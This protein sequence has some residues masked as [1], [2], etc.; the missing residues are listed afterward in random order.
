MSVSYEEAKRGHYDLWNY[1][2]ESGGKRKPFLHSA[3]GN[4]V[5]NSCWCCQLTYDIG[6]QPKY[7][8]R[9]VSVCKLCP[10]DWNGDGTY[11]D[12]ACELEP[13]D[14]V[15]GDIIDYYTAYA[16]WR[17]RGLTVP[18]SAGPEHRKEVAARIRDLPWRSEEELLEAARELGTTK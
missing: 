11:Y 1:L 13:E 5:L 3:D 10:I 14:E 16:E 18:W 2:A 9:P 7:R 6:G 8:D 15:G 17:E 12:Y 4:E